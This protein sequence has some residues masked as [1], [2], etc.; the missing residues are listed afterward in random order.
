[1]SAARTLDVAW[2]TSWSS[3]INQALAP[4]LAG[5]MNRF[6]YPPG[7]NLVRVA[8]QGAVSTEPPPPLDAF[9]RVIDAVL[10]PDIGN[11]CFV[12]PADQVVGE[13]REQG[14]VRLGEEARGIIFASD[15]ALRLITGAGVIYRSRTASR[16]S[17]F[18]PI[19]ED[20]RDY[21]EQLRHAVFGF[22]RSAEL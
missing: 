5:F 17:E 12:H 3:E 10:L 15:G 13:L 19:G 2:L 14:T 4:F 6:G 7:D 21:L 11:G 8:D 1:M 18:V 9:Y 22:I 16:D 20:L